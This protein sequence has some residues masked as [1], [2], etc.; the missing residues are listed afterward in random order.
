MLTETRHEPQ[1]ASVRPKF[2]AKEEL[3]RVTD[4]E[5]TCV[6]NGFFLDYYGMPSLKSHMGPAPIIIDV[7]H[8][9]A[10]IPGSGNTTAMFPHTTDV[11][12]FVTL[13]LDLEKW[14]PVSYVDGDRMTWNEFVRLA[15]EAK[16]KRFAIP[17]SSH[18]WYLTMVQE[19]SST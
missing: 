11:A 10:A 7:P 8:N 5:T 2:L 6:Q 12:K 19:R 1:L 13:M 15:E 9:M 18:A 4:L 14:D 17:S 3:K 16:G